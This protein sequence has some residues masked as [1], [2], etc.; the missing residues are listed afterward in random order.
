M[1]RHGFILSLTTMCFALLLVAGS[2]G[3]GGERDI[4]SERNQLRQNVQTAINDLDGR[5][6]D[7][8]IQINSQGTQAT[9]AMRDNLENLQERRNNLSDRLSEIGQTTADNWDAFRDD[10]NDELDQLRTDMRG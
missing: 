5:I 7:L 10:L 3:Q 4:E 2:C 9:Q 6:A 8:R 1:K